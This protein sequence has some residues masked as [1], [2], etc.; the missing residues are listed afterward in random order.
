MKTTEHNL[1]LDI[2]QQLNQTL[3]PIATIEAVLKPLGVREFN[4][5]LIPHHKTS[6]RIP[7]PIFIHNMEDA[8]VKQIQT[9]EMFQN[10]PTYRL[11]RDKPLLFN[12]FDNNKNLGGDYDLVCQDNIDS[13]EL[14]FMQYISETQNYNYSICNR[15]QS[16]SQFEALSMYI[17]ED[18][19]SLIQHAENQ[20]ETL[21]ATQTIIV[22]YLI[23]QQD[24]KDVLARRADLTAREVECLRWLMDGKDTEST[25]QILGLS[26]SGVKKHIASAAE[27]L[28]AENRTHAV[29]KAINLGLL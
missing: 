18:Q 17:L 29:A 8:F 7:P 22:E 16:I 11:I 9:Q 5:S 26:L 27:K 6:E 13:A 20:F 10:D 4:F 12:A 3:T 2:S 21:I 28:E 1:V 24:F 25:A 15:I 23:A 19:A 14:S